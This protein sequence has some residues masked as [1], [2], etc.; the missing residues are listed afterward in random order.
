MRVTVEA[1]HGRMP[2]VAGTGYNAAIGSDIAKRV[3]KAG[4]DFLLVLPPYYSSAPEAGLF[5]FYAAIGKA[6][7]LADDGLQSRLGRVFAGDGGA[8]VRQGSD[9]ES[10]ERRPGQRTHLS[11]HHAI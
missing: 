10:L 7:G 3:E 5:D 4:A 6:T 9:A 11:A 1:T 2:V 8:A